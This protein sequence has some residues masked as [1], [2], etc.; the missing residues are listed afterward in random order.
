MI[1][2]LLVQSSRSLYAPA[3]AFVHCVLID[4][5]GRPA[6]RDMTVIVAGGRIVAIGASTSLPIP[7]EILILSAKGRFLI[8]GL[9]DMHVHVQRYPYF[10]FALLTANGITG[11]RDMG[12]PLEDL[13][14]WR[15]QI[16][17]REI[18]GP[19]LFFAGP[20]LDGPRPLWN[21]SIA[22]GDATTA[23][24]AVDDLRRRGADFIKIQAGLPREAYF[25][26][27]EESTIEHIPFAGHVPDSVTVLEASR[28]GQRSIEHLNGLLGACSSQTS[29]VAAQLSRV[30][31]QERYRFLE[32]YLNNFSETKAEA[33][34]AEFRRLHTWQCPT[35][36]VWSTYAFFGEG[37][38]EKDP[39]LAWLPAPVRRGWDPG[40]DLR[41]RGIGLR[42]QAIAKRAFVKNLQLV[43]AMHRAGVPLLAGTDMPSP[44]CIPGFGLHDELR[45]LVQA[46]LSPMEALQ[47][48]TRNPAR[49]LGLE[50]SLG[51][52]E[53][54]KIADL[55]LLGANPLDDI[56]NVNHVEGVMHDGF[57]LPKT[58]IEQMLISLQSRASLE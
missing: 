19:K 33:L 15:D 3:L 30:P 58:T 48:A 43:G 40:I 18:L 37:E 53:L 41:F 31:A 44:F 36:V 26:I 6:Q 38:I 9:W 55:V 46:G 13:E 39:R 23:R 25:A 27:A 54:G 42:E 1:V 17:N 35:L 34:F 5:T 29:P 21:P 16:A 2:L 47:T 52:I 32:E 51:T 8:P 24:R 57:Y 45:L 50:S 49:Y 7:H 14:H 12:G 20:Y 4:G 22:V 11:A 56:R 10:Y 28:A